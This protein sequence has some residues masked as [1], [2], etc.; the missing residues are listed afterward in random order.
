MGDERERARGGGITFPLVPFATLKVAVCSALT[1]A[2]I[3]TLASFGQIMGPLQLPPS[4][5]PGLTCPLE[6]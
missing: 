5:S 3:G 2:K 4:I 6:D 1:Y